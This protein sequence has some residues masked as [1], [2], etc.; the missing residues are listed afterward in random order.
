MP[1]YYIDDS[2]FGRMIITERAQAHSIIFHWKNGAVK[3][4]VP[5]GCPKDEIFKSIENVRE[6]LRKRIDS[7]ISFHPGDVIKCFRHTI[8]IGTHNLRKGAITY[9]GEGENLYINLHESTD[10]SN[11]GIA[12]AVSRCME[13]LMS[14]NAERFLIPFAESIVN[15]LG[16]TDVKRFII[17]RGKRKL[18][19]CTQN[20]EIQL[21]HNLMFYPEH[22]VRFVIC[23]ELAH[24][25]HMNHSA[26]FHKLCDFYCN[27]QENALNRELKAFRIPL[28]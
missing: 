19:H 24:L 1:K 8:T 14:Q 4:T 26:E 2:E 15:E 25:K 3:I 16:I 5:P 9:G 22:L 13:I 10:F 17:G 6:R 12:H 21:S 23:H 28:A 11:P 7:P 18:G 20:R 27:G